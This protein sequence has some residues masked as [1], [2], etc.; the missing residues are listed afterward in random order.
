MSSPA[1]R[2]V[3]SDIDGTFITSAERVTPR[4]ISAIQRM[5]HTETPLVLATGRPARWTLPVIRQL[6]ISPL[7]VCT[8]GSVIFDSARGKVLS[9][10]ELSPEDLT[11]LM[12]RALEGL[13]MSSETATRT[14]GSTP[15][16]PQMR[17]I[18]VG[19]GVERVGPNVYS[20]KEQFLI[21]PNFDHV[22]ESQDVSVV[23]PEKLVAV[24]AVKLLIRSVDATSEELYR[25][26]APM[27]PAELGHVTYSFSGGLLEISAPGVTKARGLASLAEL[28]GVAPHETV[29][30]G[31]M[32]NDTEMLQWAQMGVA[33]GNG[34]PVLHEIA[35][36]VTTSND[37]DGVARVLD[38]W[39]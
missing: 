6:P 13:T 31:D 33:M 38:V 9:A 15:T 39:F 4:L 14:T 12:Q 10:H 37:D 18:R 17:E 34:H 11:D 1:P 28:L 21:E 19:F 36:A 24:P 29:A 20:E 7:C 2:L 25:R 35:Q 30:F 26:I 5:T 22:W 32:P 16:S 27:I 8:N 3:A 23:T